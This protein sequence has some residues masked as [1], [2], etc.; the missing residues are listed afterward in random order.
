MP[1]IRCTLY[2]LI[3]FLYVR[4]KKAINYCEAAHYVD[5]RLQPRMQNNHRVNLNGLTLSSTPLLIKNKKRKK[6]FVELIGRFSC[7]NPLNHVTRSQ[8]SET[9][10]PNLHG[11]GLH[12]PIWSYAYKANDSTISS[13]WQHM[14]S[15][16]SFHQLVNYQTF[17]GHK[18]I[19]VLATIISKITPV[20]LK[21]LLNYSQLIVLYSSCL[22]VWIIYQ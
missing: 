2:N 20:K 22:H 19:Q 17:Q 8:R 15:I 10:S 12:D 16:D 1:G 4:P 13:E 5:M 18:V 9:F 11:Q 14:S 21:Q 6:L 7:L 3:A